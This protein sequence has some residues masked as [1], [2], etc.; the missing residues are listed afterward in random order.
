[1]MSPSLNF[2]L[3]FLSAILLMTKNHESP[4][5][6]ASMTTSSPITPPLK[7]VTFAA[8]LKPDLPLLYFLMKLKETALFPI[9]IRHSNSRIKRILLFFMLMTRQLSKQKSN[10]VQLPYEIFLFLSRK[11]ISKIPINDTD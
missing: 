9:R 6:T 5:V 2:V 3:R 11:P 8:T 7:N 4:Y 10:Y 1:M